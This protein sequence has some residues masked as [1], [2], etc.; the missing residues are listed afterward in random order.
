MPAPVAPPHSPTFPPAPAPQNP[1]PIDPPDSTL[2]IE[3]PQK[4]P[5]AKDPEPV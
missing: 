1:V 3:D 2:P 5:P 4:A